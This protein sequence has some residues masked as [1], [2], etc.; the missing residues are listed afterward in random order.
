ME[1]IFENLNHG[2]HG[3]LIEDASDVLLDSRF[4]LLASL[5]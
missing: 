1:K 4:A 3:C 2:K 5:A